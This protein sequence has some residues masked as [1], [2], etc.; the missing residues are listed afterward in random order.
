[1]KKTILIFTLSALGSLCM[2]AETKTATWRTQNWA[3][4]ETTVTENSLPG[5]GGGGNEVTQN[6][7]TFVSDMEL[8]KDAAISGGWWGW[9]AFRALNN[10]TIDLTTEE[11]WSIKEVTLSCR[12]YN[13]AQPAEFKL[14]AYDK[15]GGYV[16]AGGVFDVTYSET[17]VEAPCSITAI[18]AGTRYVQIYNTSTFSTHQHWIYA[19]TVVIEKDETPVGPVE[20]YYEFNDGTYYVGTA[21]LNLKKLHGTRRVGTVT[22][23]VKDAG[24]TGATIKGSTF[25][26]TAEGTAVVTATQTAVEGTYKE[27]SVDATITVVK[28][29]YA[30]SIDFAELA[31]TAPDIATTLADSNYVMSSLNSVS[32][33]SQGYDAPDTG[34]KTE[35]GDRDFSFFAKDKSE[36]TITLGN[37]QGG[38]GTAAL[39]ANDAKV[40]DIVGNTANGPYTANGLTQFVIKIVNPFWSVLKKIDIVTHDDPTALPALQVN[41]T[42]HKVLLNNR[43]YIYRDNQVSDV[44]GNTVR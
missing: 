19:I 7:V 40:A 24:T 32:W 8:I 33:D 39:Y 35:Y 34:L 26:A 36:V 27:K 10:R 9:T 15:Q 13:V 5:L 18:P 23:T 25:T 41:G 17:D 44:L 37:W 3:A 43:L 2:M 22:Y 14:D 31:A 12:V 1:M 38:N 4:G 42:V 6:G 28:P 20:R 21:G 11:G 30:V 16:L 29:S